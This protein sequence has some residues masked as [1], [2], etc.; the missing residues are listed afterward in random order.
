MTYFKIASERMRKQHHTQASRSFYVKFFRGCI[1]ELIVGLLFRV[2]VSVF[3]KQIS[4]ICK[5][6]LRDLIV[7]HLDCCDYLS[8]N[9]ARE[10]IRTEFD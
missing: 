6:R 1:R 5:R 2:S 10:G 8:C 7:S 3:P 9:H 4:C